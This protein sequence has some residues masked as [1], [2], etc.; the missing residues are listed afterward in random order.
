MD[1]LDKRTSSLRVV[2]E[3]AIEAGDVEMTVEPAEEGLEAV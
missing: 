2:E 3:A 1:K